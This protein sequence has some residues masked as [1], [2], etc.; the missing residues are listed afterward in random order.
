MAPPAARARPT[1]ATARSRPT[2]AATG[3]SAKPADPQRV[4]PAAPRR[5]PG[6]RA[7]RA[8]RIDQAVVVGHDWGAP[9]GVDARRC[10]APTA[11]VPS[12]RS[13]CRS[14]RAGDA[15]P[16]AGMRAAFGDHVVLLPV[17]PGAGRAEAEL[18]AD[19]EPFLRGFFYSLSGDS[20][21]RAA[22]GARRAVRR[23]STDARAPRPARRAPGLADRGGPRRSTS[24]SSSAP[25]SA[26]G[27]AG[28]AA[29]I[30]T[31]S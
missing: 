28:T 24:A 6:R 22:R 31:G 13:A 26:A 10:C 23:P 18:D 30:A 19:V 9:V 2:C 15:A 16:T 8:R 12:P 1:P 29:P 11:S 21:R 3:S 4:H 5:R 7:R 17:L 14:C 25:G 27:V 20:P